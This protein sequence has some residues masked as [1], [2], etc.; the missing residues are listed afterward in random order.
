M[1]KYLFGV[2][3]LTFGLALIGCAPSTPA[4][5]TGYAHPEVL[6]DTTWVATHQSDSQVRLLDVSS[7]KDVYDQ[8]HL[9]GAVY[10]SVSELTNPKNI[11][12]SPLE[13][14]LG[15][16]G[17][18]RD[19][20]IVLYDDM[21]SLY[22]ARAFFLLKQTGHANLKIL[23]GGSAAWTKE[24]RGLTKDVPAFAAT[25]YTMAPSTASDRVT[26][27]YVSTRLHKPYFTLVDARS[28][29]EF[30]GQQVNGPRGG[31]IPGAMNIEWNSTL[32]SDGK[33]RSIDELMRLYQRAGISTNSDIVTY[34]QSGVRGS[35]EWF[36]LK[37][38]VGMPNVS[39][40]EGSW[41]E[42]SS[43]ADLP[44]EIE[45]SVPTPQAIRTKEPDPCE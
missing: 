26:V 33:F 37:Y 9:S 2:L 7:K 10:V 16:L 11:T 20:T 36:V 25:T 18:K 43:R 8:G 3:I 41:A 35:H 32:M 12:P 40:Y 44:V 38:L 14:K 45:P 23:N 1:K 42:W 22:A 24:N 4:R 31:H 19:M 30:T 15:Q 17:I 34:C 39:L 21:S 5:P 6:A 29:A 27:D 28:A 13:T